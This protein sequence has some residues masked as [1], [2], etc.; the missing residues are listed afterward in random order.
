MTYFESSPLLVLGHEGKAYP[1][2]SKAA[3]AVNCI[4]RMVDSGI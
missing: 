3:N 1:V 4:L 2:A